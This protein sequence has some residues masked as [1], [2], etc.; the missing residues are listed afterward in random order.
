NG[1]GREKAGQYED[2]NNSGHTGISTNLIRERLKI[3]NK[4]SRRKNTLEII[5]LHDDS[6]RP[7]GTRVVIKIPIA[8]N[9]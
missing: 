1:I 9:W 4:K 2:I 5:D 6:G 3:L 8:F 7:A